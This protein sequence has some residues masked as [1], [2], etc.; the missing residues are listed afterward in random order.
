MVARQVSLSKMLRRAEVVA[1]SFAFVHRLYLSMATF[2]LKKVRVP[3]A[4]DRV[5]KED[6]AFCFKNIVRSSFL[7]FFFFLA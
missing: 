4:R 2:D 1:A 3:T 6:C 5:N 7:C